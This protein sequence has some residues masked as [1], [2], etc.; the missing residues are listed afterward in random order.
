MVLA[1][2]YW[3]GRHTLY[4]AVVLAVVLAVVYWGG[5]HTLY[6]AV[7]LIL[8]FHCVPG[9]IPRT[10]T[11][12]CSSLREVLALWLPLVEGGGVRGHSSLLGVEGGGRSLCSLRVARGCLRRPPLTF[13]R[14]FCR[15]LP[16]GCRATRTSRS[17][18]M[19]GRRPLV[20]VSDCL[21]SNPPLLSPR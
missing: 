6:H 19:A 7:R 13:C 17:T 1:V 21:G 3:G 10:V 16:F 2:V 15:I 8:P 12:G 4:H 14:A 20:P 11:P 9:Q 5:R 18:K